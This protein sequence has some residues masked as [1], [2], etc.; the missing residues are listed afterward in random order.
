MNYLK[1]SY[2]LSNAVKIPKIGLGTWLISNE[3]VSQSVQKALEIGYRHIDTAQAYKNEQGVGEGIRNSNLDRKEIFVTTK[4]S[5]NIKSYQEAVVSI[6]KS[7]EELGL[8][9][10]DLML[11]HSPKPWMEY[12]NENRYYDENIEVWNALEEAYKSGKIRAIGL[13]NFLAEDI[14]NI[15][16]SC[17]VRPMVNQI[18]A[19]IGNTPK[20]LIDYCQSK[21]I[22]IEAYSPFAHGELF[23]NEEI[24]KIA[25]KYK[26]SVCRLAMRYCLELGLLPL[27]K[28][29]NSERMEEN[30]QVDFEISK[31]DMMFLQNIKPIRDYGEANKFPVFGGVL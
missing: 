31:Q 8:D 14:E 29:Q 25:E 17:S 13:S 24:N 11:I 5:A 15:L 1:E 19:H 20:K 7:I 3:N 27:P 16:M 23:K 22:L 28:T 4:L 18:L 2:T 9:Y 26:V 30:A 21:N 10:I 6:D 12:H